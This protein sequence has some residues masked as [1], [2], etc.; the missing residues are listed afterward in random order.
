M[1]IQEGKD[2]LT[3]IEEEL[4]KLESSLNVR[5]SHADIII[6]DNRTIAGFTSRIFVNNYEYGSIVD[7]KTAKS[8]SPNIIASF[9]IGQG[10]GQYSLQ[11]RDK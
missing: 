8:L 3:Q 11:H 6:N 5:T 7:V 1:E 10:V 4:T 2:L 9:L